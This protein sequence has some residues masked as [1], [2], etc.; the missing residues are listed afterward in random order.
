MH[1]ANT[2]SHNQ[3]KCSFLIS[4][5]FFFYILEIQKCIIYMQIPSAPS[6]KRQTNIIRSV[7]RYGRIDYNKVKRSLVASCVDD[8]ESIWRLKV[9]MWPELAWWIT[10]TAQLASKRKHRQTLV[11]VCHERNRCHLLVSVMVWPER[12]IT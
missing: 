5:F 1:N 2:A 11:A 9:T 4:T 12:H 8:A 6:N 10:T 7:Q 3:F